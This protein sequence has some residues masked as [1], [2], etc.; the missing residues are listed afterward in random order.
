MES[1]DKAKEIVDYLLGYLKGNLKRQIK[2]KEYKEYVG[3]VM[4]MLEND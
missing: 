3:E 1:F 2:P 4:W